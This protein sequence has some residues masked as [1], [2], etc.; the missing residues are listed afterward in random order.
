M[1]SPS[2]YITWDS[3]PY[4]TPPNFNSV[5]EG[6]VEDQG[7]R[8]IDMV[9]RGLQ[10][11][12]D[13]TVTYEG[14]KQGKLTV[15]AGGEA[16]CTVTL[17]LTESRKEQILKDFPQWQL[18]RGLCEPDSGGGEG[19][20]LGL[21]YLGFYADWEQ[22]PLFDGT[23][24]GDYYMSPTQLLGA[25]TDYFGVD[26]LGTSFDGTYD[27]DKLAFSADYNGEGNR[28]L[29]LLLG[30]RRNAVDLKLSVLD[31]D[32]GVMWEYDY[33][34]APKNFFSS[35]SGGITLLAVW[36][37]WNGCLADGTY[38]PE[39]QGYI[40]R[41]TGGVGQSQVTQTM[42]IPFF[43]DHTAPKATDF[44]SGGRGR[45]LYSGIPGARQSLC[46]LYPVGG[47]H[48]PRAAGS[49]GGRLPENHGAGAPD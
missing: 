38:A 35:N 11:G 39:G 42:D 22:A 44:Y 19:V 49:G 25:S 10:E 30:L 43:L 14:L 17:A 45:A 8:F 5:M 31:P 3:K 15:P 29:A 40:Y 37:G 41:L 28:A 47:F 33:D 46:Q 34:R 1:P 13:Y 36:D 2:G 7:H 26:Y 9:T 12:T 4:P 27:N 6:V 16:V 32:G 21:P 20:T 18:R 48:Q 24:D 23:P